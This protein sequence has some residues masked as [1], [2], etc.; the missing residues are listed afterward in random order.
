MADNEGT[1][2]TS[3]EDD[4]PNKP[5]SDEQEEA[6]N[7]IMAELEG[8]EEKKEGTTSAENNSDPT[9]DDQS[10]E[11]ADGLT[12]EQEAALQK[13]MAEIEG[14]SEDTAEPD[15][16]DPDT[17]ITAE[18]EE[19]LNKIVTELQDNV[20]DEGAEKSDD[21]Q[22]EL[23]PATDSDEPG[24][25][26]L[27]REQEEALQKIMAEIEAKTGQASDSEEQPEDSA[28]EPDAGPDEPVKSSEP[29][30]GKD[31][32]SKKE[33]K[34]EAT[35]EGLDL[36]DFE[37]E[38]QKVVSE[39][40][41]QAALDPK[42]ARRPRSVVKKKPEAPPPKDKPPEAPTEKPKSDASEKVLKQPPTEEQDIQVAVS[43][44]PVDQMAPSPEEPPL[45][46]DEA[47]N[48]PL[49][50]KE[51]EVKPAKAA[52]PAKVEPLPEA[53]STPSDSKRKGQYKKIWIGCGTLAALLLIVM[54]LRWVPYFAD[55]QKYRDAVVVTDEN[56]TTDGAIQKEEGSFEEPPNPLADLA[57]AENDILTGISQNIK[58]LRESILDKVKEIN[59]LEQY[60]E[61]GIRE[62]EMDLIGRI[63]DQKLTRLKEAV[64]DQRVELGLRTIQRRKGYIE[65]LHTPLDRMQHAGEE[66][67]YLQRKADI[68]REMMQNTSGISLDPFEKQV[69][70]AL[71]RIDAARNN[72]SM[73][74]TTPPSDS[75]N[76]IWTDLYAKVHSADDRKPTS[77]KSAKQNEAIG[78]EICAGNFDRKY[79]LTQLNEKTAK[80]LLQWEG[81]DLYLNHLTTLT[82]AVAQILSHWSGEWLGLN[83]LTNLSPETARHLARWKG[84][85]LSLNGLTELS[86]KATLYLS[87][88]QGDQLELVGLKHIGQWENPEVELFVPDK[89]RSRIPK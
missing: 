88:W 1:S 8:S 18:Q 48:A 64:A 43:D 33:A 56:Q 71:A 67:L 7:K 16:S 63:R 40:N 54:A 22:E 74:Q 6:L 62:I 11:T 38:L 31:E 21:S 44:Q 77:S 39:A 41:S 9:A 86:P 57:R 32:D 69:E 17:S 14:T 89:L 50:S 53:A 20:P 26:N 12:N 3:P 80:C 25:E 24:A 19:T 36:S 60:Y 72:L 61:Q 4:T 5:L 73:D 59:D 46:R 84:K 55:P 82:P 68:F 10:E 75:L 58:I 34:S 83:G 23:P 45:Q 42:P 15:G 30:A 51:P 79:A 2:P 66:L 76:S 70:E 37:S 85:R 52:S 35:F 29:D 78:K 27:N 81:K 65:K 87:K 47:P 13:I 49:Q 28:P